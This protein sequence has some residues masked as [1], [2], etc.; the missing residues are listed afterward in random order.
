V[1][2]AVAAGILERDGDR[3]RLADHVGDLLLT[4]DHP[5]HVGAVFRVLEHPE[6]FDRFGERLATGERTWWDQCSPDFIAGVSATGLPFYVRLIP[7]GL[8]HVS[9]V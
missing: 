9:P 1:P 7:G 3:L 2:A 4:A 6:I 5:A 8:D